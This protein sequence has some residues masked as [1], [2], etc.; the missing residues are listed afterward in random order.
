MVLLYSA[1]AIILEDVLLWDVDLLEI[2]EPVD[3]K[4]IWAYERF[5]SG[6]YDSSKPTKFDA[7]GVDF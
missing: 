3:T 6:F 1:T 2:S 4:V 7:H 5:I